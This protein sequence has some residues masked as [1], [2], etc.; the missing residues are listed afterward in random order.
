[1]GIGCCDNKPLGKF[2]GVWSNGNSARMRIWE[3]ET[4]NYR[5]EV[6]SALEHRYLRYKTLVSNLR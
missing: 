3:S 5:K 6:R 2:A 4:V 1:M